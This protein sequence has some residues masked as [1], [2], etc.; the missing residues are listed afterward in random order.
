MA[1]LTQYE[2][3]RNFWDFAFENPEL[4]KPTHIAIYFFALEHCNRLGWKDKF[5]LPTSM[6]IDA[7]GVKSYHAYKKHFDDLATWGFIKV[8]QY[9]RNQ[10]SSNVISLSVALSKNNK[11]LDKALSK[12]STKQLE[13]TVQSTGQSTDSIDKQETNNNIT[14][15]P[16]TIAEKVWIE[17]NCFSENSK[18]LWIDLCNSKKWKKKTEN[19]LKMSLKKLY[20]FDEAFA[21]GLM[22]T[23]IANDYQG[24][25]FDN[26]PEAYEKWKQRNQTPQPKKYTPSKLVI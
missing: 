26:T 12:H 14:I 18:S 11:A 24:V 4:V 22:E 3:S 8:I 23:A 7:I 20:K 21:V 5:G 25:V 9:S 6:V 1:K 19:A 15:E 2:L 10:Y 16:L 17:L 13:S